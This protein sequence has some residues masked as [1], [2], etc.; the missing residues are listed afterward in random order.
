MKKKIFII[1][2]ILLIMLISFTITKTVNHKYLKINNNTYLAVLVNGTESSSIPAKG[3]YNVSITC[4]NATGSWDFDNWKAII[5]NINGTA[6]CSL[7]FKNSSQ[8]ALSDKIISLAGSTQGTGQVVNENGYRYEGKDPNNYI[9][10]NGELW[11]IIG[12]FDDTTHGVT[13]TNLVKIMRAEPIGGLAWDKSN[14][15][16]WPNSSLYHLL[17]DYYYNGTNEST[18]TYCYGYSTSVPANCDFTYNG[19]TNSTYRSMIQN[20]TW[21]LGGTA[22]ISQN[23]AAFYTAERGTTV[24]T[25][26]STTSTGNIGLMYMSDYGYSV[27]ASSC[28][29]TTNMGSYNSS[30]CAGQSWMYSS[31]DIWTITP[32]SS[33]SSIVWYVGSIGS[34]YGDYARDAYGVPAVLYLKSDVLMYGG[35]GSKSNP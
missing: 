9:S 12:V 10:F 4:Q 29:R 17:N 27:L 21:H 23:T 33:D 19:I 15:N 13:G 31:D 14:T 28:A 34:A 25:G 3:N 11:R 8:V 6:K 5:K 16:D 2:F 30:T 26:R 18:V 35:N 1:S 24:Y 22:T 7:N 32:F 20:V